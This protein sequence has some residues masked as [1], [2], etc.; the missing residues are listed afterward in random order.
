VLVS[1]DGVRGYTKSYWSR[2]LEQI[3]IRIEAKKEMTKPFTG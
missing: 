3:S 2:L 1:S